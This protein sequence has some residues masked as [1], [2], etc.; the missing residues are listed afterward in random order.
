MEESSLDGMLCHVVRL[1][2]EGLSPEEIVAWFAR[3]GIQDIDVNSLASK[4]E[5]LT[6]AE[7]L[8]MVEQSRRIVRQ[9]NVGITF[10]S[11]VGT[12]VIAWIFVGVF[13]VLPFVN[14]LLGGSIGAGMKVGSGVKAMKT[15]SKPISVFVGGIIGWAIF[16]SVYLVF[17]GGISF[18]EVVKAILLLLLSTWYLSRVRSHLGKEGALFIFVF[19]SLI[20]FGLVFAVVSW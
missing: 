13:S 3:H 4:A 11:A 15:K 9:M 17:V 5:F 16:V 6:K 10:G 19:L 2:E 8:E 1:K 12:F 20:Y 14:Q 18:E 7:R